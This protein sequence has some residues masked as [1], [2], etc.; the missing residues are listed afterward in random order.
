M[1]SCRLQN[2]TYD[3]NQ[4]LAFNYHYYSFKIFPRFG[5]AK[6]TRIIY[7]NLLLMTKF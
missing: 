5:L 6:S 4:N 2:Y 3:E 1:V 7:H